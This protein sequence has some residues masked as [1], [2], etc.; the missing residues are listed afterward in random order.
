MSDHLKRTIADLQLKLTEQESAVKQTKSLINQLSEMAG[1]GIIYK[2]IELESNP[3]SNVSIRSDQFYGQ[4]QATCV[5]E[6]LDMRKALDQGPATI[7]EIFAA[8]QEGGFNF[9]TKNDENAK[10]GLRISITKNTALFHKLPN[11]KIGLL[12]WYP[13][14]KT[15]KAAPIGE[16]MTQA[17]DEEG[18]A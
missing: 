13:N 7:N 8:L 9:E 17:P 15:K 2:D 5:R 4:P 16:D 14:A 12:S 11:G 1:A 10:R 6:F 18:E 3:R